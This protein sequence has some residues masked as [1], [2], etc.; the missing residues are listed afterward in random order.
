MWPLRRQTPVEQAVTRATGGDPAALVTVTVT[1]RCPQCNR[2]KSAKAD[3]TDP[4]GT[5][6]VRCLC[7]ACC[8]GDFS[9]VSYYDSNGN[10]LLPT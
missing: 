3:A 7:P 5:S 4:K 10:A 8:G 2:T 6:I 1:L 9:E